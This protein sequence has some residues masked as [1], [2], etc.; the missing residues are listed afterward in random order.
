MAT[1]ISL[2]KMAALDTRRKFLCILHGTHMEI[3]TRLGGGLE[4]WQCRWAN[5]VEQHSLYIV[6]EE[7]TLSGGNNCS[8]YCSSIL[9]NMHSICSNLTVQEIVAWFW[10]EHQNTQVFSEIN[11]HSFCFILDVSFKSQVWYLSKRRKSEHSPC[12]TNEP[13]RM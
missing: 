9:Q 12:G 11:F 8:F 13:G 3:P 2:I 1:V 6:I 4:G 7:C 5:L 10:A